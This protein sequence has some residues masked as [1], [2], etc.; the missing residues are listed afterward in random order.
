M[1]TKPDPKQERNALLKTTIFEWWQEMQ[2]DFEQNNSVNHRGEFARLKR[3]K[4]LEEIL[5]TP[6]FQVL[7]WKLRKAGYDV[8]YKSTAIAVVA[9]V[10][11]RVKSDLKVALSFPAWLARFKSNGEPRIRELRFRRLVNCK[12]LEDLFPT[13][14]R[15]L[16][17]AEDIA[18]IASLATDLYYWG[19]PTRQR[20]TMDYYEM[21][22]T[23]EEKVG[24]AKRN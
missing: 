22:L 3:C 24:K 5:L 21:L 8:Q 11:V 17:L 14:I 9:G 19:E 23:E 6:R 7:R 18:P 12:R 2:P 16:P 1:E 20:W 10:L 15:V 4:E 13:L